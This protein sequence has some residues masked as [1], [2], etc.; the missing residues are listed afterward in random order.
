VSVPGRRF[1]DRSAA[2]AGHGVGSG[3]AVAADPQPVASF[4]QGDH[5]LAAWAGGRPDAGGAGSAERVDQPQGDGPGHRVGAQPGI[6]HGD[7]RDQ[8]LARVTGVPVG[9]LGAARVAV[10]VAEG[11]LS[12]LPLRGAGLRARVAGRA[13]PVL[14]AQLHRRQLP[15]AGGAPRRADPGCTGGSQR[16]QEVPDAPGSG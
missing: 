14:A 2:G 16:E 11:D 10:S 13:V 3:A 1:A 15:P 8:D 4:A 12:L 5:A 6:E 9:T 7:E